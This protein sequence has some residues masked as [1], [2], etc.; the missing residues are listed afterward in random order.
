MQGCANS[1]SKDFSARFCTVLKT[2]KHTTFPSE[3]IM[4]CKTA[5]KLPRTQR[6]T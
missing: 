3:Y 4:Q 1:Y 6:R 2:N 5:I